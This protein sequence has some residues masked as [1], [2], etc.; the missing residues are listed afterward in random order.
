MPPGHLIDTG[1]SVVDYSIFQ[2]PQT[3]R[4]KETREYAR[5]A[6]Q[7]LEA[8]VAG[9]V[10]SIRRNGCVIRHSGSLAG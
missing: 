1:A 3:E 2:T 5:S 10:E 4:L 7:P 8:V 9:C 6:H